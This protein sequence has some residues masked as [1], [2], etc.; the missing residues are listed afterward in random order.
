[1]SD[2]WER[3]NQRKKEIRELKIGSSLY[4]QYWKSN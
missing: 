1:M 2:F 3:Q 4:V